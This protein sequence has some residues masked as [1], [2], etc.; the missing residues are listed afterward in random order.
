MLAE[1][2]VSILSQYF[3]E[4]IKP[5]WAQSLMNE[6]GIFHIG[7]IFNFLFQPIFKCNIAPWSVNYSLMH[8]ARHTL[9]KCCVFNF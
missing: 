1:R 9:A 4:Y 2:C 5:I 7:G 3:C 8:I 6:Y